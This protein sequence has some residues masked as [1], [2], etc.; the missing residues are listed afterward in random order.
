MLFANCNAIGENLGIDQGADSI[1]YDDN[2]IFIAL[3]MEVE[4]AVADRFLRGIAALGYP[5]QLIDIVLF[6]VGRQDAV[7]AIEADYLYCIN[8]RM[9][10]ESLKGV[11]DDG[12]V[13]DIEKLLGD[14]L[15]HPLSA[16]AGDNECYVHDYLVIIQFVLPI[17]NIGAYSWDPVIFP[18]RP[19][20]R[21]VLVFP[22]FF[23]ILRFQ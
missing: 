18:K 20:T 2:V 1:V 23:G 3:G 16:A 9:L 11:Y 12:L 21:M 5:F 13:I 8:A 4:N 22:I 7:P 19:Y 14:V 17:Q 6:G 10:L 15:P